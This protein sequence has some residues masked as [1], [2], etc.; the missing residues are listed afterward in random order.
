M[1]KHFLLSWRCQFGNTCGLCWKWFFILDE[2][3]LPTLWLFVCQ[4][5]FGL[6]ITSQ[7]ETMMVAISALCLCQID[8]HTLSFVS[9]PKN[10]LRRINCTVMEVKY[11]HPSPE[12]HS[13]WLLTAYHCVSVI[14]WQLCFQLVFGLIPLLSAL[15]LARCS[16][17]FSS[18]IVQFVPPQRF[19]FHPHCYSTNMLTSEYK[20]LLNLHKFEHR[21]KSY[22]FF[23]LTRLLFFFLLLQSAT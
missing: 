5:T 22:M 11:C 23:L 1:R 20:L 21:R 15:A 7:C 3:I 16:H 8:K 10:N 14:W 19:F 18:F 4:I 13:Q 6:C 17:V 12:K 9:L 2:S